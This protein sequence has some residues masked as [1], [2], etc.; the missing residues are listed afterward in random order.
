MKDNI[1]MKYK[2]LLISTCFD[3]NDEQLLDLSTPSILVTQHSKDF[4][5]DMLCFNN[6]IKDIV[7]EAKDVVLH[8]KIVFIN[9]AFNPKSD[10]NFK[11]LFPHCQVFKCENKKMMNNPNLQYAKVEFAPIQPTLI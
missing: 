1:F 2:P 6:E 4:Q 7:G 5:D 8:N 10:F 11:A 9:K 3:I